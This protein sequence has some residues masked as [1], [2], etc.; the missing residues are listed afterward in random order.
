M[1]ILLKFRVFQLGSD[2]SGK[3]LEIKLDVPLDKL[4]EVNYDASKIGI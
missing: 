4:F 3:N 2:E 1:F